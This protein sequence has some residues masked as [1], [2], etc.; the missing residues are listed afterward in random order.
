MDVILQQVYPDLGM[1]PMLAL[2]RTRHQK[3]ADMHNFEYMP[4][5][6]DGPV[7]YNPLMGGWAKVSYILSALEH[8]V[9]TAVWLDAD[10]FIA[11]MDADLRGGCPE[12]IGAVKFFPPQSWGEHWNVGVLYLRNNGATLEFVNKWLLR[13]PG[14]EFGREQAVFNELGKDFVTTLP[15]KWNYTLNRHFDCNAPIVR[16]FHG[17][18]TNEQK[19]ALMKEALA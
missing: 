1:E 8:H 18:G 9:D 6:S 19:L 17:S 7:Q 13:Y 12:H 14:P 11:D 15:S 5:V 16:G 4:L 3:Y 10:A 2:T